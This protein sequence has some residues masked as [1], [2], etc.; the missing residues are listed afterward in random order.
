MKGLLD[1]MFGV[2]SSKSYG[3]VAKYADVKEWRRGYCNEV[4]D[5]DA[6]A[7]DINE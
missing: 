3:R 2:V 7:R 5:W 6:G 1:A 4:K